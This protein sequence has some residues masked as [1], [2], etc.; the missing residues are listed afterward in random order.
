MTQPTTRTLQALLLAALLATA[1]A[2]HAIDNPDAP[3]RRAAFAQ[4]AKPLEDRLASQ[5]STAD[6]AQAGI[7]Y[8]RFLDAELN[9][10]Y[11]QLLRK[12]PADSAQKLKVSQR[13]W[14]AHYQAEQGFIVGHW[15]T[16][17]F[18]TSAALSRPQYQAALLKSRIL[19]LLDYLQNYPD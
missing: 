10:T 6:M 3:D 8:V 4:R 2:S 16:A 11:Q 13:A 18:G 1:G 7:D 12:L 19:I 15:T 5:D 9:A 14:L 17:R